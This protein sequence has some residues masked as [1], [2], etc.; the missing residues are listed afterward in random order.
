MFSRKK[1]EN[2]KSWILL[3]QHKQSLGWPRW[4]PPPP[5]P[6]S[7]GLRLPTHN[8]C[9]LDYFQHFEKKTIHPPS[10]KKLESTWVLVLDDTLGKKYSGRFFNQ[11]CAKLFYSPH[12]R[13]REKK[14]YIPIWTTTGPI[15]LYI[16]LQKTFRV[17]LLF[18]VGN[19][20]KGKIAPEN[21]SVKLLCIF[22]GF[23]VF[24]KIDPALCAKSRAKRLF[25]MR[26]KGSPREPSNLINSRRDIGFAPSKLCP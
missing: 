9:H 12:E 18:P 20:V 21:F 4:P 13:I 17:T 26:K 6:R 15:K 10:S 22:V 2:S 14:S 24:I 23:F 5:R 7:R 19:F 3:R 25:S 16:V 8:R 11:K 1:L